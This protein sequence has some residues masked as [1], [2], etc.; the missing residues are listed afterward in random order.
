MSGTYKSVDPDFFIYDGASGNAEYAFPCCCC[1]HKNVDSTDI[2]CC[3]CGHVYPGTASER[4]A[5][6]AMVKIIV[7]KIHANLDELEAEI[8]KQK[9][10]SWATKTT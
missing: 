2:P 7:G 6:D 3:K 1:I 5:D 9:G 10:T 8:N 4:K